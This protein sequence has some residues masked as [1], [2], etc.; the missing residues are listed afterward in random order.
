MLKS[1]I[2]SPIP[3][4]KDYTSTNIFISNLRCMRVLILKDKQLSNCSH[5]SLFFIIFYHHGLDSRIIEYRKGCT[6]TRMQNTQEEKK[7]I[8][9]ICNFLV[10]I[11]VYFFHYSLSQESAHS[12]LCW[13]SGPCRLSFLYNPHGDRWIILFDF[14][15]NNI[16]RHV[17]IIS[18]GYSVYFERQCCS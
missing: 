1:N 10:C 6:H 8:I 18:T 4:L 17:P 16:W 2:K 14:D 12:S 13:R 15:G 7:K 11:Y 3:N 5:G 9:Y